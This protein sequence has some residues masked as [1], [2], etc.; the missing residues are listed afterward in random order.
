M[1]YEIRNRST[2]I[3]F[4]NTFEYFTINTYFGDKEV[5]VTLTYYVVFFFF[6]ATVLERER[7]REE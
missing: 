3:L 7:W 5:F 4:Q 1:F 2:P 6:I